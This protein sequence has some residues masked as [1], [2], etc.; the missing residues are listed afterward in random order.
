MRALQTELAELEIT[1]KVYK[2]LAGGN[3]RTNES[4]TLS[5]SVTG[6]DLADATVEG[7]SAKILAEAKGQ[8]LHY[9][10]VARAAQSRGYNNGRKTGINPQ[11]FWA[12]MHRKAD[13]FE[14]VGEGKFRLKQ[15]L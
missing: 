11:T 8:P 14:T 15:P 1:A 3:H 9:R 4:P 5:V 2:Q 13:I 7:A 12:I 10:D 6:N